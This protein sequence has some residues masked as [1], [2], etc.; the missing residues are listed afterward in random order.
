M[1]GTVLP[2]GFFRRP[3]DT[4]VKLAELGGKKLS[5][6]VKYKTEAMK[7]LL[8]FLTVAMFVSCGRTFEQ[9]TAKYAEVGSVNDNRAAAVSY[10]HLTLPTTERV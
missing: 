6:H 1:P 7:R 4:G 5:L 2:P 9:R 10:T 8:F 3:C